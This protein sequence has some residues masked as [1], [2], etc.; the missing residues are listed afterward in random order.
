MALG[1]YDLG[2]RAGDN[3]SIHS[4]NSAEW[5]ICDLA[6]L[7]IGAA[8]VPIYAT[9]PGDQIRYILENSDAVV[10][11]VS[12]DEMFADTKPLIKKVKS[13]K[14]VVSIYGSEHKK[15]KTFDSV[16]DKGKELDSKKPELFDSL[17][18]KIKPDDLATLIYTSGTTGK[19]K[20]VMLSHHN[21][22]SN[23]EASLERL[24]FDADQF[25]GQNVLSYLPLSHVFERMIEYMYMS[26]GCRIYYIEN[27]EGIR[28]DMQ[29]VKPFFL[30]TVPRLLEKI[31]T[32]VKVKGQELSG[33]KKSL[34]YWA[35]YNDRRIRSRAA[36]QRPGCIKA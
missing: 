14:S 22:V 23:V 10:H 2:V 29:Y 7:S 1:L 12:T 34:Y 17:L 24:P 3:V 36:A 33:L 8:T 31:H 35:I 15:L 16:I 30:A 32:G 6:V 5:I 9:Q 13:V 19:P 25:H 4:E 26:M 11:I 21:I 28:D 18:K 27:I 20:G